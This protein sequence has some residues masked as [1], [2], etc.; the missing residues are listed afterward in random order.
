MM[1]RILFTLCMWGA[2]ASFAKAQ[3]DTEAALLLDLKKARADYEVASQ[4]YKNDSKLYEEKALS[5]ND[6]NRSKNELLSKE[7][8]YQKLILKLI[9]Q[10]SYITVERAVK[11]QNERGN[12]KVKITLTSALEGNEEYLNQFQE[13]FDVFTPEMR[14]GK[15]YNIYVSLVDNESKTIIGSPYEFRVPAIEL[16][17]SADADFELLKDA[18]DLT[19]SLNYN[20]RKDE[21]NIYLKKDASMNQIDITSMQFSQEADL[22]SKASY[23]ITLERFSTSDDVYRLEVIDLPRQITY[24]FTDGGSKVTQIKFAQGVNVKK[25]SLQVYLPDRDDEQVVIDQP[26]KFRVEAVTASGGVKAGSEQLEIIPRGKG[27]IEVRANNLYHETTTGK[28]VTMDVVVRNGGS[29]RLDNIKV[30]AEKPLGWEISI[31]PDIIRSLEPEKEATLKVTITPP[32]EGGVGAQ[33]VKIK[34]EAMADNRKVD[35]EDKTVRIQVNAATSIIGT[36][37][38]IL[39]LIAF[40]GGI[41]WFGMKLSKK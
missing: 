34:T 41:V 7:V 31:V 2:I 28:Q 22:S 18:E 1:K 27:K 8:D 29:R 30:S 4:K 37:A 6:F 21:K 3:G 24:D 15:I 38:L 16:G 10:Q 23:D 5:V 11:Y 26:V 14:S 19:V 40:I 20:N 33:E 25:L 35:T 36:L 39:L 9:S 17:K 13:H 12:R 32:K